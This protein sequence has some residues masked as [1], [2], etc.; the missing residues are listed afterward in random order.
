MAPEQLLEDLV[1][2]QAFSIIL[3]DLGKCGKLLDCDPLGTGDI[4][5]FFR[6]DVLESL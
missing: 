3:K 2:H 4:L 6:A 1:V 5:E